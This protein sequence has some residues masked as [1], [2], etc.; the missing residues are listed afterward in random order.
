M[1]EYLLEYLP[2]NEDAILLKNEEG[3]TLLHLACNYK[4]FELASKILK[5]NVDINDNNNLHKFTILHC[6]FM[7]DFKLS[8]EENA[9]KLLEEILSKNFNINLLD[10]DGNNIL[11]YAICLGHEKFIKILIDNGIDCK[12]NNAFFNSPSHVAKYL[13]DKYGSDIFV[14]FFSK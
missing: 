1:E 7:M 5:F 14:K 11:H 13:H 4:K 2:L 10:D 9:L 3:L 8:D 12:H 6:F